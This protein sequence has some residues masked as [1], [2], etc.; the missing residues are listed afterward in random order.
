MTDAFPLLAIFATG[1]LLTMLLIALTNIRVFLRLAAPTDS[2][3]TPRVSVLVPARNEADH[4]G[5][6]IAHLLAQ[7]YPDFEI[8]ILDDH[9]EDDTA[10]VAQHAAAG[11]SCVRVLT[12]APLPPGW[13]GKPWA[14]HQLSRS[15]AGAVLVFTDA[16]VK[17]EP[18]ALSA[19]IELIANNE[20]D[21]LTVWPTQITVTW[22]ERLVVPLMAMAVLAYLPLPMAHDTRM[23]QAAAAN[24]QCMAFRRRAYDACGGHQAVAGRIVED[25][26]LAEAIKRAGLNL[27]M[28]DG[29]E[30]I[31]CRMYHS[32]RDVVNGYTKNIL[33]G[34]RNSFVLL[35]A[36][37]FMHLLLFVMPWIWLGAMA[38]GAVAP[39]ETGMDP[40]RL[41]AFS[42]PLALISLGV[43][44]RAITAR[45]SNQ[46]VGDALLMPVSALIMTGIAAN[47]VWQQL[48]YGGHRWKGRIVREQTPVQT[49]VSQKDTHHHA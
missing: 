45:A 10:A 1:A 31:A 7:D 41:L 16:D 46:R 44:I 34:H 4:L 12:G 25:V 48:R 49:S 28:A 47:A 21:L 30:T 29:N 39:L 20:A 23:V 35:G 37:T 15:A 40:I 43:A 6:T 38:L 18:G 32:W 13:L 8:L 9:S 11:A 24:G 42:W 33:A 19:I 27:R 14:C 36:S 17:W 26:A 2:Q 22:A 3:W 5:D